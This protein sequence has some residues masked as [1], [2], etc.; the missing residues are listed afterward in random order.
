M[1]FSPEM[2]HNLRVNLNVCSGLNILAFILVLIG[3]CTTQWMTYEIGHYMSCF[4]YQPTLFRS[5]FT[6]DFC[7]IAVEGVTISVLGVEV[8]Q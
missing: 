3:F 5:Y 4:A 1:Q 8:S 7:V 2:K 6:S